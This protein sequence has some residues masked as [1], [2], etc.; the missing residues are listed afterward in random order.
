MIFCCRKKLILGTI[1][2]ISIA[3]LDVINCCSGG[4]TTTKDPEQ[5]TTIVPDA[6]T[7]IVPDVTTPKALDES[8]TN[9]PNPT[10]VNPENQEPDGIGDSGK[11]LNL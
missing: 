1:L 5:T 11:V 9:G 7:P 3:N 10:T 6:T 2:A 4:K 8:T